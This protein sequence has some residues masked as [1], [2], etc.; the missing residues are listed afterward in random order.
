MVAP[1]PPPHSPTL[2]APLYGMW[3]SNVV[4]DEQYSIL[5]RGNTGLNYLKSI[6]TTF[7]LT[8]VCDRPILQPRPQAPVRA[9]GLRRAA[10]KA[11]ISPFSRPR[12][13]LTRR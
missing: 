1:P 8:C 11:H 10:L 6:T 13:F 3:Y 7:L 12:V 4:G 5:D 9:W 2:A